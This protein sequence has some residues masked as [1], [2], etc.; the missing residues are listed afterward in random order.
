M[1]RHDGATDAAG[2]DHGWMTKPYMQAIENADKC[3]GIVLDGLRNGSTD[4]E[5]VAQ[6]ER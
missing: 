2:H 5:A 4:E 6:A 1:R 3:I